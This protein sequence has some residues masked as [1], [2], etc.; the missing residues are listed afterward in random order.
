[1]RFTYN[2]S[3]VLLLLFLG[4]CVKTPSQT[5]LDRSVEDLKK[6]P[7]KAE[8]Y[9]NNINAHTS[10]TS[11]Q[12]NYDQLYFEPWN[13]SKPPFELEPILWPYTSYTYGK[14]YGE[15]LQLLDEDWFIE[16]QIKG[17]FEAY[18]SLG[19][20]GISL[21]Y[22]NLRNFPTHKPVFRDP[23][24]AGE[25]F[26]FDY[27]QNSGVHTNE[28]LYI[29]HLSLDGEWAYVFTSYATGWAP[30]NNIAF[31]SDKV[32]DSWQK[33]HQ[34]ELVDEYFPIKDL[35]GNFIFN[36]RVGMRL[37]LI[38]IEPTHYIA[39]AITAG[40]NHTPIYAKVKV[41]LSV[42]QKEKMTI[43]AENLTRITDL[44]LKSNYGWGGLYEE[45][46]CSSMLRDLYA[47]F[48][49]WLP[50]NSSEQSKSGTVISLENISAQE[51]KDMI[52]N[53]GIP[54]ETLLYKQGHIL[55]YLGTY[56]GEVTVLHNVWG[57]K[58]LENGIEGRAVIGKVVISSLEIG[59]EREDY[60]PEKGILSQIKSMNIITQE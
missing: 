32:A 3:I 15:N 27:M 19:Q 4:G 55:L 12:T 38:S 29:S 37:P 36:S 47:P 56:E 6:F 48:G 18:G 31:I 40:R 57:I 25:G 28:P 49:I 20:K 33:S 41:P 26:P 14:S 54:F 5:D 21:S 34:I 9:A 60:N 1:M 39:L 53:E 58:T 8:V 50:R 30:L 16:M 35:E 51:K 46:D 22:L 23:K 7:Q 45:R 17:N 24:R 52:I 43:N 42:G 44:M 13:Y 10:L 59:K 11:A 2:V